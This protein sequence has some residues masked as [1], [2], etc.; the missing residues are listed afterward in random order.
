MVASAKSSAFAEN[1]AGQWLETRSLDAMKPD[2]KKFP[3][4]TP[5]LKDSMATETRLFF[6]AVLRDD[7]PISD[8]IDGRYTFLNELLAKNYGIEGVTGPE[9][10][11][12]ELTNTQRSGVFTQASVLTI[13]SY[14]TR[15]S[16]V[17]RGHY[18]MD[19]VLN[20]PPPPLPP[21]IPLLNEDSVGVTLSLRQHMEQ[22]RADPAC[23]ACHVK[24]DQLGFALENY[25]ATGK[26]RTQDGR[27]PI[28]ATGFLPGGKSF[29]GPAEMKAVLKDN[30]EFAR[31]LA[32][33]M[34]TY[35]LGRG[36]ESYDRIVIQDLVRQMSAHE[37]KIQPLVFGIVHSTPFLERRGETKPSTE[38]ASR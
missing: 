25:D 38:V 8:F 4:W 11:R 10:R 23:A 21:G 31:A 35:A 13:S 36:V 29:N 24:T 27:F 28:D 7:R 1:F 6:E 33:R 22:H 19:A 3:E 20:A 37:Y 16:V 30:P 26:W 32:T 34:L 2:P 15:T 18:I 14:P 5:E 12:V 17:L 9:F